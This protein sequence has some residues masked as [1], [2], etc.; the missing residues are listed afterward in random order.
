MSLESQVPGCEWYYVALY[1]FIGGLSAGAYF[2]GSLVELFGGGRHREVS[3]I[4]YYVAFPVLLLAPVLLIA[5]QG[6]PE[7]FWHLFF[8][9]NGGVPAFS[10]MSPLSVRSWALLIFSAFTFLSFV[11]NL[12]QDGKL[13]FAPFAAVY[14]RRP[15]K[16]YALVGSLAGFFIASC[17]GVLLDLTARPLWAAASPTLGLLFLVSAGSVG[18]A[19]IVLV[20]A[21]RRKLSTEGFQ[22]IETFDNLSMVIELVLIAILVVLAGQLAAPLLTGVYAILFW[23]GTVLLGLV[24]PLV[25]NWFALR[26]RV[27]PSARL[28]MLVALLVLLGGALLRISIVAG[29][30]V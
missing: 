12:V 10:I 21:A 6:R 26:S 23:G 29:G 25:I 18:A 3:K 2:I 9:V 16:L 28:V 1:F 22:H 7:R 14:N 13:R 27:A 5:D 15:R 30:Q 11:D 24:V 19:A 17:T 8:Y 4:A 20:L